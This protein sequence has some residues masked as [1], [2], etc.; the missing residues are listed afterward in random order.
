MFNQLASNPK[1]S[2]IGPSNPK[3]STIGPS[4]PKASTIGPKQ[5]AIFNRV[6]DLIEKDIIQEMS[7]E[8]EY[9]GPLAVNPYAH[10]QDHIDTSDP[11]MMQD[12]INSVGENPLITRGCSNFNKLYGQ[13]IS[14]N[15]LYIYNQQK[16]TMHL[17]VGSYIKDY[18]IT[19]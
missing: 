18:Q 14:F 6:N 19:I 15:N 9:E 16:V 5:Q 8:L 2:T 12:L 4:N 1:A 7:G 13:Y 10:D 3:A 17:K 11:K